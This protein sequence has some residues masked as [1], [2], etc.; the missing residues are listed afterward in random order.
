MSTSP[1]FSCVLLA[2]LLFCSGCLRCVFFFNAHPITETFSRHSNPIVG[3]K[4]VGKMGCKSGEMSAEISPIP[5]YE[6]ISEDAEKFVNKLP[7]KR[8]SASS[9]GGT[10]RWCYWISSMTFFEDNT[11][12]HAVSFEIPHD[13][14]RWGYVLIYDKSNRRIKAVKH[15]IGHY[16]S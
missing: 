9:G 6:A 8:F 12:Q 7:V 15:V 16:M 3:W 10:R 1:F 4:L 13:G 2:A 5:G 14:T 11:G